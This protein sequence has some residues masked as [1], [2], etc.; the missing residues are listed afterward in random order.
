MEQV[1]ANTLATNL[2]KVA[3]FIQDHADDLPEHIAIDLSTHLWSWSVEED[4]IPSIIGKAMR[5]SLN[6]GADV[7]KEYSDN[8]FRCYMTWGIDEPKITWK[9]VSGRED[10]CTKKVLGTHTVTKMVAPEGDWTEQEVEE[11]VIEW[12]CHSLLKMADDE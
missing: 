11:D 3:L 6:D 9:I 1:K 7:K 12:E 4:A 10:V 8:Y 2:R 5:S